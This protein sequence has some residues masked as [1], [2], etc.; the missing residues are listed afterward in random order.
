MRFW[1]PL[2]DGLHTCV[3]IIYRIVHNVPIKALAAAC[4]S[5]SIAR[6]SLRELLGGWD[7]GP[8]GGPVQRSVVRARNQSNKKRTRPSTRCGFGSGSGSGSSVGAGGGG[9]GFVSINRI[10][11]KSSHRRGRCRRCR[12]RRRCLR[13]RQQQVCTNN[14]GTHTIRSQIAATDARKCKRC[15]GNLVCSM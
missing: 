4:A 8:V 15:S 9:G 10:G 13:Q 6:R 7:L 12:R 3:C 14:T 11:K 1:V 5:N 2:V